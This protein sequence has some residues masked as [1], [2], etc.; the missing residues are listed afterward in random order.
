MPLTSLCLPHMVENFKFKWIS[1]GVKYLGVK[2]SQDLGE[3]PWLNFNPLLEK[4]KTNLAKWVKIKFTLWRK[5]NS[6][7]FLW[8][9]KKPWIKLSKF[10]LLRKKGG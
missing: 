4:I 2:L 3:L 10:V 1:K 5:I 7:Q 9:G 8:E 6:I